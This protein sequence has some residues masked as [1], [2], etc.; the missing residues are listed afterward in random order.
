MRPYDDDGL[1]GGRKLVRSSRLAQSNRISATCL[2]SPKNCVLP[3][4]SQKAHTFSEF[5]IEFW[6]QSVCMWVCLS[7]THVLI[8][9]GAILVMV[10]RKVVCFVY[11]VMKKVF[12][13]VSSSSLSAMFNSA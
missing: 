4:A 1:V 13:I 12:G 11:R 5:F 2:L 10:E 8:S 3:D 7:L 9:R 6:K